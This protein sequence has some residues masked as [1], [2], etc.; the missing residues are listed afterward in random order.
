V[1]AA[2][3]LPRVP[4]V[5]VAGRGGSASSSHHERERHNREAER[6]AGAPVSSA[7]CLREKEGGRWCCPSPSCGRRLPP[8]R[9]RPWTVSAASEP[10]CNTP[11]FVIQ[12]NPSV[13]MLKIGADEK[14]LHC[15]CVCM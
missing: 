1:H 11:A 13:K 8:A 2:G 3:L 15:M 7:R 5:A 12:K 9:A 4:C 6:G 10:N 14:L